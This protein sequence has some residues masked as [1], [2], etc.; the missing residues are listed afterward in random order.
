MQNAWLGLIQKD[1]VVV[2]TKVGVLT[3]QA[4]VAYYFWGAHRAA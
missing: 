2:L 3:M 1:L 4:W